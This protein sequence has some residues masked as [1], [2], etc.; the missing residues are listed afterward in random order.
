MLSHI[1]SLALFSVLELFSIA[2]AIL[3][4]HAS[5]MAC[6]L[7]RAAASNLAHVAPVHTLRND[8]PTHAIDGGGKIE[9]KEER[10][11]E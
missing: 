10:G 6:N 4:L 3:S 5:M 8:Q 11:K 7:S 2:I 9:G 1:P